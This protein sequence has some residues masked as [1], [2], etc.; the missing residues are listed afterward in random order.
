MEFLIF[1]EKL[2]DLMKET[3]SHI[4]QEAIPSKTFNKFQ[5]V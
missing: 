4:W 1:Q 2:L 3:F 5:I